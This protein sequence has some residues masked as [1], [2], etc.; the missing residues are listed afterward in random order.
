MADPCPKAKA[1]G[2]NVK[3]AANVVIVIGR[4][5]FL[6]ASIKALVNGNLPSKSRYSEK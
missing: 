2:N 3:I 5:R 1:N 4:M 6:P